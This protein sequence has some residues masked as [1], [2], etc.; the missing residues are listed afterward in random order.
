MIR[1]IFYMYMV[2][3]F[4]SYMGNQ[5]KENSDLAL[6]NM[7]LYYDAYWQYVFHNMFYILDNK[8]G[9]GVD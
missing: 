3:T 5:V 2:F 8:E 6:K 4:W 7:N 9:G 1:T